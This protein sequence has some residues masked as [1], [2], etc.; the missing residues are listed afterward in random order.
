MRVK[1]HAVDVF[2]RHNQPFMLLSLLI[3]DRVI[4]IK[5][6]L[7]FTLIGLSPSLHN[8]TLAIDNIM[9]YHKR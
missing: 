8:L 9:K 3:L 2:G 1:L 4:T 7:A 5:S 6:H